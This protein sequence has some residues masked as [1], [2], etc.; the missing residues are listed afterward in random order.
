RKKLAGHNSIYEFAHIF[1]FVPVCRL[2]PASGTRFTELKI[3]HLHA[4]FNRHDLPVRIQHGH[5]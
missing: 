2:H 1:M 4:A 5:D 3:P